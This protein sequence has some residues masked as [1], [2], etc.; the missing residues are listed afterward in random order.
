MPKIVLKH[1]RIEILNYEIGDAPKLEE[2]F[3]FYDAV[4]HSLCFMGIEYN[5][6]TK[7]LFLP[8]GMD[9][10]FLKSTFLSEPVVIYDCDPYMDSDPIPIKS[11][12]RDDKQ[13]DVLKFILGIEPFDRN[14]TKSQL[15]VNATTGFGKTYCTIASICY[16][17]NRTIIIT[18]IN[19]WLEQWKQKIKEYTP[20]TDKNIYMLS[21]GAGSYAIDKIFYGQ[22]DPLNYQIFLANH[23]TIASYGN[24]HGWDKIDELFKRLQVS[25]KVY[26]EAH[27]YFDNMCRIDY[28]SDTRL[29]LYLTATPSK[30]DSRQDRIYQEY[31][32]N[33][34]SITRY[35]PE[36]DPHVH[37]RS[38]LYNSGPTAMDLHKFTKGPYKF[39]R[40]CYIDY[41]VDQDIFLRLVDIVMDTAL[42]LPGK[43]LIFI[44][45]NED[46]I[47]VYNYLVESYPFIA[48]H[49]GIFTSIVSKEEKERAKKMKFI[50][51]TTMSTGTASD[52]A[53]LG[54]TTVLAQPF[55]SS[56]IARQALG[57]CRDD[58]TFFIDC[59]DI[60]V[61][62]TKYY[63]KKRLPVFQEYAK[64]VRENVLTE[65]DIYMRSNNIRKKYQDYKVMC[66][67]VFK[68]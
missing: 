33:I 16:T 59:V 29:T 25:F 30:S 44:G 7:T 24:K 23:S 18:S 63:Y 39:D 1:S 36:N 41:L 64:S 27:L 40:N 68:E 22:K 49:I 54:V 35:D 42:N 43:V 28:H 46:L 34:P 67:R 58:N 20:L 47:K 45:K 38:I 53:E 61:Y 62:R 37:Y 51:S 65:E 66:M 56:V 10:E 13:I 52:I 14:K 55:K 4:K 12:P 21:S 3:S 26:D 60:G 11:V 32:R 57:R 17:G 31:F 19:D 15:S 50:L 9:I 48:N 5:T 2:Y 6:D 8:R